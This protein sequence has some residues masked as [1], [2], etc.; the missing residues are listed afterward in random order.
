MSEKLDLSRVS[1]EALEE[2]ARYQ[3]K[4]QHIADAFATERAAREKAEN[5][6]DR[7]QNGL[8]RRCA[9]LQQA[10]RER[11][12]ALADLAEAKENPSFCPNCACTICRELA[13][14]ARE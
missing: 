10:E 3:Q 2:L 1:R 13:D 8:N 5:E 11:D 14:A 9:E 7:L 12:T 4:A 6:R